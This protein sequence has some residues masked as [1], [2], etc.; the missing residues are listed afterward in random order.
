VCGG[1]VEVV[2]SAPLQGFP[3]LSFGVGWLRAFFSQ[4]LRQERIKQRP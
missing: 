4:R 1:I 3:V 2:C